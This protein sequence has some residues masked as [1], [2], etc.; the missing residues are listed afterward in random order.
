MSQVLEP[1]PVE[2]ARS[3][4]GRHAW[5][6]AFQLLS[7]ADAKGR[8]APEEL[9]LLAQAAWWV[10]RLPVAIEARERAYGAL[11]KAGRREE[12]AV[13]AILLGND[14]L[15]RLAIP[16]ATAW[17]QRAERLLEGMDEGLA[18][19]WLAAT[20]A[21]QGNLTGKLDWALEQASLA[22]DIAARVRDRDLEAQALSAKGATLVALGRVAEGLA[23]LDEATVSA[24]AGELDPA[25]AGGISCAAIGACA[26]LG[27]WSRAAQWTE[28]QDRWCQREGIS[29][30]PGMC[31]LHRAEMKRIKGSWMEAE[32]EAR[33][34]SDELKGFIP[35][36][37]GLALYQIGEIR[38]R[39]GDLPTAEETLLRAHAF[40]RDPEPAL[41]LLRLAEG[42]VDLASV[43]IKRALDES[44]REPSWWAPPD[45][46][47][48]RLSLLPAQVEIALAAGDVATARGAADEIASLAEGFPSIQ[49]KASAAS[50][51]GAVQLAEGDAAGG[52][53]ALRRGV[54][55]WGELDAPYESARARM[56]LAD[57]YAAEGTGE[58]AVMEV[59]AARA[60]FE[61]L[62]AIPDMRRAEAALASLQ[63]PTDARPTA[64][65]GEQVV[66]T[67]VFTDIV[68]ST[69]L[70]EALGDE[71]WDRLLRWHDQTLRTLVGEHGGE[72][73]KAVGDGFFLAFDD[74]DSAVEY[75]IAMQRRLAERGAAQD[76][77]LA[78]RVGVHRADARRA[79]LDYTGTGVNQA[80]RIV[81]EAAGAEI[82]VSAPT[83]AASRRRFVETGRRTVDLRG[84]SAPVEVVSID[85][86]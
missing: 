14:N 8:L 78:V 51:L 39:R 13:A 7:E 35:A 1:S 17:L 40:G 22:V 38:L 61:Q 48:Y 77:A 16:V 50:A 68:D 30:F 85:W 28:A 31:R 11:A 25:T 21:F 69:R 60:T 6:E 33:R 46:K 19:G 81:R 49:T 58:R 73:V 86:R 71:A 32:A 12:A 66:K 44:A 74:A 70:A 42:K 2:K 82:L 26:A 54:Q 43:S 52:A 36:A 67:F 29:G 4:L 5:G 9:E 83:L 3:A 15:L 34:A 57:A 75:A 27:D 72:E 62:G 80:A 23:M 76:T 79:R 84:I 18:H 64:A 59:Q 20:R 65:T 45:S 55:L 56:V 24:V 63:G 47:L 10:G 53:Q 37:V 41:S